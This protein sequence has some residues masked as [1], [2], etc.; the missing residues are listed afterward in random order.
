MIGESPLQS[1]YKIRFSA[2]TNV[3]DRSVGYQGNFFL[4]GQDR[5]QFYIDRPWDISDLEIYP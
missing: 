3:Y 4:D 5:R 1:S 2:G